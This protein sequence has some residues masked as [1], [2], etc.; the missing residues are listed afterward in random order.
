MGLVILFKIFVAAVLL[1]MIATMVA[2]VIFPL[3]GR[4]S[5]EFKVMPVVLFILGT[6]F[7]SAAIAIVAVIYQDLLLDILSQPWAI[8]PAMIAGPLL[9][10]FR[11][12]RPF[13]YGVA[14]VLVSWALIS[15][16]IEL[17]A[18][19]SPISGLP[20]LAKITGI[21]AGLYVSVRGLDNMD[22]DVPQI[23]R[24]PWQRLFHGKQ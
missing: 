24:V 18:S 23:F 16:A 8:V 5:L 6:L 7:M 21:L 12:R 4:Q 15:L 1:T 10:L 3:V 11:S 13:A 17:P 19:S 2:A 14:E 20:L 22:K 9:Y